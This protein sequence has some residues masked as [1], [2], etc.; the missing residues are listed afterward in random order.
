MI[1]TGCDMS[2]GMSNGHL[3]DARGFSLF[4]YPDCSRAQTHLLSLATALYLEEG[5]NLSIDHDMICDDA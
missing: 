5:M 1:G 2:I 3:A 4:S